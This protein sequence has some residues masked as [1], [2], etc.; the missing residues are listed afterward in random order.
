MRAGR[1]HFNIPFSTWAIIVCTC[2]TVSAGVRIFSPPG[3]LRQEPGRQQC[4]GLMMVP[5]L[6][7]TYLVVGQAGL[8]FGTLQAFLDTMLRF[9][10]PSEFL[11]RHRHPGIRQEVIVL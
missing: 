8:A 6:P 2:G 4:Q 1:S 5:T 10:D 11:Q 3:L 9:E 7:R